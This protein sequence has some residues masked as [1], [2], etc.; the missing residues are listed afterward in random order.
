MTTAQLGAAGI[1]RDDLVSRKNFSVKAVVDGLLSSGLGT[2]RDQISQF[3]DFLDVVLPTEEVKRYFENESHE[4]KEIDR[5]KFKNLLLD[6]FQ[7]KE[8]GL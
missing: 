5:K 7:G 4:D 3:R 6:R 2:G 8:S 1:V